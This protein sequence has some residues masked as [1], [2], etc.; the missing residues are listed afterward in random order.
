MADDF[1]KL[2]T[3]PTISVVE[4]GRVLGCGT[5]AAYKAREA[6]DI[7]SIK[8]GGQYRVPTARLRELLGLPL[9]PPASG[10]AAI[11]A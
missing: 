7:P 4:A 2:L 6:G 8:V 11:A 3:Q 5:N 9:H 10:S 1:E